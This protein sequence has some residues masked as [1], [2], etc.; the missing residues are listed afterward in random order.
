L[1]LGGGT[2]L[3][4]LTKKTSGSEKVWGGRKVDPFRG[5]QADEN[6]GSVVGVLPREESGKWKDGKI[7]S[8][9]SD[10]GMEGTTAQ[11]VN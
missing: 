6:G 3:L 11:G 8:D 4:S 5:K 2:I 10:V 1:D 7:M 9:S